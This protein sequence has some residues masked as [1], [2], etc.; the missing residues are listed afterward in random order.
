M[1]RLIT[2]IIAGMFSMGLAVA[3]GGDKEKVNFSE[4]DKDG[5][6]QLSRTEVAQN[7]ELAAQFS[8]ID[9]DGDGYIAETE[10]QE[11]SMEEASAEDDPEAEIGE[12]Y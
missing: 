11:A 12:D 1:K 4:L 2:L 8:T 10:M 5:D 9:A 7:S 3:G 6:G